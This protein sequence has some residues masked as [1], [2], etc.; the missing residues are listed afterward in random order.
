MN[1]EKTKTG[2]I[3][4]VKVEGRLD[5]NTSEQF[6]KEVMDGLEGTE[7]LKLD[8]SSLEYVSSAGLRALLALQ[9]TMGEHGGEMILCN[10]DEII[11]DLF[12]M[13]GFADIL[14]IK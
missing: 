8:C 13:T 4:A 1:M 7:C 9:K 5:T 12:E 14:T 2:D 11:M 6:Q 10:V 3:L